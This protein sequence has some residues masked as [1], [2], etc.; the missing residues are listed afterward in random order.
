MRRRII[1]KIQGLQ[2]ERVGRKWVSLAL[3]LQLLGKEEGVLKENA[4]VR[5]ENWVGKEEGKLSKFKDCKKK[6]IVGRNDGKWTTFKDNKKEDIMGGA[7]SW[8]EI[9]I[10]ISGTEQ[11]GTTRIGRSKGSGTEQDRKKENSQNQRI[12]IRKKKENSQNQRITIRKRQWVGLV[13]SW[14]NE[15]S[16]YAIVYAY[17]P[18][19]VGELLDSDYCI[20]IQSQTDVE[21]VQAAIEKSLVAMRAIAALP[22]S[23]DDFIHP[24]TVMRAIAALPQSRDDFIH[25]TTVVPA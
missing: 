14:D 6:D 8:N 9:V 7:L 20:L 5:L 10:F 3:S 21:V 16:L 12:T 4:V 24:T 2:E 19:L 11:E 22:Q 17:V 13:L 18:V 1:A 15:Q 25:P 23:R